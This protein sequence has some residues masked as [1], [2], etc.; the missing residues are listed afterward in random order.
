MPRRGRRNLPADLEAI[1]QDLEGLAQAP[2]RDDPDEELPEVTAQPRERA[3]SED[4]DGDRL[5]PME[6]VGGA[7]PTRRGGDSGGDLPGSEDDLSSLAEPEPPDEAPEVDA[8]HV[9][10]GEP[11]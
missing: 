8:M 4:D 1:S 2:F 6:N 3:S 5:V 7:V 10:R 11:R 9:R